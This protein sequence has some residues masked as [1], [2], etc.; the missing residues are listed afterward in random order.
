MQIFNCICLYLRC[1]VYNLQ[2]KETR[3]TWISCNCI[4]DITPVHPSNGMLIARGTCSGCFIWFEK[5]LGTRFLFLRCRCRFY[6][7]GGRG[8]M[9]E[10]GRQISLL[11]LTPLHHLFHHSTTSSE[12][13]PPSRPLPSPPSPF[14]PNPPPSP[15]PPWEKHLPAVLH[16]EPFTCTS[17]GE[18]CEAPLCDHI[19]QVYHIFTSQEPMTE[20]T[21]PLLCLYRTSHYIWVTRLFTAWTSE[22]RR[23]LLRANRR[24]VVTHSLRQK[25]W[26]GLRNWR[27]LTRTRVR[28]LHWCYFISCL[29]GY[30]LR[31]PSLKSC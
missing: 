22:N 4:V 3:Q 10:A 14:H 18:S 11:T 21:C 1:Q 8:E 15:P 30:W 19:I 16:S 24:K 20:E 2:Y 25:F 17:S 7:L 28:R 31:R 12:S 9:Q 6:W 29:R 27:K 13:P 23:N 26:R 5:I